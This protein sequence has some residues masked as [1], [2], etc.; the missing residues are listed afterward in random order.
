MQDPSHYCP[1]LIR[2]GMGMSCHYQIPKKTIEGR[3]NFVQYPHS[4]SLPIYTSAYF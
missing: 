3:R 1:T 4:D 2:A